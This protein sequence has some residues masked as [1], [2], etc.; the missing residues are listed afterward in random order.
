M[1]RKGLKVRSSVS[2]IEI[3]T[4]YKHRFKEEAFIPKGDIHNFPEIIYSVDSDI[5]LTVDNKEYIITAGEMFIY[6]PNSYHTLTRPTNATA[7][8]VSFVPGYEK[9]RKLYNRV[10]RLDKEIRTYFIDTVE[11]IVKNVSFSVIDGIPELKL[12][13]GIPKIQEE[14]MKGKL[15]I[16]L[17]ML[18]KG[19]PGMFENN[20]NITPELSRIIADF[21]NNISANYTITEMAIKNMMSET[22]LKQLFREQL[23]ISPVAY[24]HKL[25]IDRAKSLLLDGGKNITEISE[26]LGFQSIHYF[27]RFFKK[28][29]GV[30]PTEYIKG[31]DIREQNL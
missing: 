20:E 4:A 14:I 29:T 12:K 13:D 27:S 5:H 1:K 6:A 28:H 8:I 15:E 16:F 23:H 11:E 25:K 9:I 18:E 26:E 17:L 31:I 22:K 21:K 2:V 19:L 30:C 10:I 24:F 3:M 7:L